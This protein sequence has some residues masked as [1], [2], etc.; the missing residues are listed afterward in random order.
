MYSDFLVARG[1]I[2]AAATLEGGDGGG[3]TEASVVAEH[4]LQPRASPAN[5]IHLPVRLL[6][7]SISGSGLE[8]APMAKEFRLSRPVRPVVGKIELEK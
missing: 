6:K 1:I 7:S 5:R 3:V 4:R 2:V 8:E